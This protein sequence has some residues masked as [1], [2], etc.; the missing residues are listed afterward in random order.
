MQASYKVEIC[1]SSII[2]RTPALP[3]S[4]VDRTPALFHLHSPDGASP[5][6]ITSIDILHAICDKINNFKIMFRYIIEL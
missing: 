5:S 4:I 1:P 2:D 6:T 3:S